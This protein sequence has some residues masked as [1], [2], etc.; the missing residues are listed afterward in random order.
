MTLPYRR[1]II[2][3]TA[4]LAESAVYFWHRIAAVSKLTPHKI[5]T[6]F[7]NENSM[8][9]KNREKIFF[10][11]SF[12]LCTVYCSYIDRASN[13]RRHDH[14]NVFYSTTVLYIVLYILVYK[15]LNMNCLN[16]L[17]WQRPIH[18]ITLL[19]VY[20]ILQHLNT[21]S[22]YHA[23][24]AKPSGSVLQKTEFGFKTCLSNFV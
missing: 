7:K 8:E 20:L 10:F 21:H 24:V 22:L 13:K 1:H 12:L 2:F 9:R 3:C 11:F 4:G 17:P 16:L 5:Q 18:F 23:R 6:T 15:H 19:Q 14:G